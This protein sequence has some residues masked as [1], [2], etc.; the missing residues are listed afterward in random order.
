MT[1]ASTPAPREGKREKN[2]A[3]ID[4][5]TCILK[6]SS[7]QVFSKDAGMINLAPIGISY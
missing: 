4:I 7:H 6:R 2:K 5:T 3:D 1:P